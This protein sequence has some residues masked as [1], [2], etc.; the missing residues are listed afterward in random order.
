[1]IPLSAT[2]VPFG[3]YLVIFGVLAVVDVYH[4]VRFGTFGIANFF[5]FFL[6]LAG[7]AV[8]MWWTWTALQG[9]DWTQPLVAG[10]SLH[11]FTS[12]PEL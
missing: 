4:M 6:F 8:I 12:A 2:L 3:L 10:L 9:T 5:A 7:T 11:M 1:M